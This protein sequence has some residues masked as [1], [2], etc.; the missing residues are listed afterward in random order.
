MTIKP[1]PG[2]TPLASSSTTSA[3]PSTHTLSFP[4]QT[5]AKLAPIP[6][7][8]AHLKS[9]PSR[10]PSGRRP[11]ETRPPSLHT[12]SLSHASGSAVVRIGDTAVVCGIRAEILLTK[13]VADWKHPD[14]IPRS[15]HTKSE[16]AQED[17]TSRRKRRK[18][19]TDEIAR[20]NLLV[21]NV[22]LST[23]CSPAHLPGSP[24][25][26]LAQTLSYRVLT[27]LHTSQLVEAEDLRI[28]HHPPT[29]SITSE[30][31][32][33]EAEEAPK[34]EI[35]AYWTLHITLLFLSLDGNPFDAAWLALLAALRDVRL[36][37]AWW[38][39]DAENVLCSP[40]PEEA[41]R[42]A[43]N[44]L[45]VPLTVG[46]FS[47]EE[48]EGAAEGVKTEKGRQKWCLVDMDGF[49][50]G[51]VRETACVVVKGEGKGA[52]IVRIEKGG[53]GLAGRD[54]MRELVGA[55]GRRWREWRGLLDGIPDDG[56]DTEMGE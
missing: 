27:L 44:G 16:E 54:E 36:P 12:G 2:P 41:T 32:A 1:A 34:P 6:F 35:K 52:E 50:E 38:D 11:S 51:C 53:G 47:R 24:P 49:E 8:H 40:L 43:L 25:S 22:E 5:F 30:G 55:A 18:T 4:A 42:L 23:G 37:R 56:G 15:L 29:A 21:P 39:V 7:L 19:E 45:P 33:I 28:W 13:D 26:A 9:S 20:L 31:E 17:E 46:M 48:Q 10:R 3:S 14:T